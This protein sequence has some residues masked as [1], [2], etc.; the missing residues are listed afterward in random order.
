M[1]TLGEAAC[2][3][4]YSGNASGGIQFQNQFWWLSAQ[5]VTQL[6]ELAE[7]QEGRRMS[8]QSVTQ[9]R[10]L[11]EEQGGRHSLGVPL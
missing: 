3:D 7:V 2:N 11:A 8:A 6:R 4:I 5:S 1:V 10:E 9:L